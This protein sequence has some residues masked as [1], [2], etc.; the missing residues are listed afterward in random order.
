MKGTALTLSISTRC[1]AVL[2]IGQHFI[3]RSSPILLPVVGINRLKYPW[4]LPQMMGSVTT[5]GIFSQWGKNFLKAG[6]R[7]GKDF[8]ISERSKAV[9]RSPV[10]RCRRAHLQVAYSILERVST[11]KRDREVES[12]TM[13]GG[14]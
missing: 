2:L 14:Y 9:S 8:R 13:A 6:D 7:C 5:D 4:L 10:G 1:L 3:N 12:L 11:Y